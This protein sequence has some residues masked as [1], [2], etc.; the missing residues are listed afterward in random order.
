MGK[1]RPAR[2]LVLL[3]LNI[4]C[5]PASREFEPF[6]QK[7]RR[8]KE[9]GY[10]KIKIKIE[11]EGIYKDASQHSECQIYYICK[12]NITMGYSERPNKKEHKLSW[13]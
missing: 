8:R 3:I 10:R 12:A 4:K 11:G 5:A 9:A 13:K 6:K 1:G 2:G 7:A